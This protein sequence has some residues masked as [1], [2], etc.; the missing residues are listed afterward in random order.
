MKQITL[1]AIC[2]GLLGATTITSYGQCPDGTLPATF[3]F[4][5]CC[6]AEVV[7]TVNYVV[8]NEQEEVQTQGAISLSGSP[9][10]IQYELCLPAGC[11][12]TTFSYT[13]GFATAQHLESFAVVGE[14]TSSFNV[15]QTSQNIPFSFG[16]CVTSETI[17][18]QA[19]F[20]PTVQ[21][22]G[23]LTLD[24]TSPAMDG[25]TSLFGWDYGDGTNAQGLEPSHTYTANGIY[26]VCLFHALYDGD[27]PV[28]V[29]DT[30]ITIEMNTVPDNSG[31]PTEI[32]VTE[33]ELCGQ[34]VLAQNC[35]DIGPTSWFV[36]LAL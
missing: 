26:E 28:C 20:I 30:C 2:M 11:Y 22:N 36:D 35:L 1:F 31:C 8:Y 14:N 10:A 19:S 25:F 12:Y 32:A 23:M 3:A 9:G 34:Y 27:I 16:F 15:F 7:N 18:C 33:G 21:Q 24:N 5:T 29:S 4:S 13:A 17:T 6:V